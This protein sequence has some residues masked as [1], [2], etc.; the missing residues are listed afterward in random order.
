MARVFVSLVASSYSF[1]H[2]FA[3][4]T[5]VWEEEENVSECLVIPDFLYSFLAD[6]SPKSKSPSSPRVT[7]F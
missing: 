7:R 4:T 5:F 2:L 1:I 3:H 6:S